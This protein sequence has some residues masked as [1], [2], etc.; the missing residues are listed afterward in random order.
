M[1]NKARI[2][3]INGNIFLSDSSDE[4]LT[5]LVLSAFHSGCN[6]SMA[7]FSFQSGTSKKWLKGKTVAITAAPNGINLFEFTISTMLSIDNNTN[8]I[9]TNTSRIL[10]S[11]LIWRYLS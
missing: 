11:F 1:K 5:P 7:C 9:I 8:R 2:D 10:Y 6:S 3:A 4:T